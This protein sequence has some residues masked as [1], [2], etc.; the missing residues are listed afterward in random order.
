MRSFGMASN[1]LQ[2]LLYVDSPALS[3]ETSML[4]NGVPFVVTLTLRNEQCC[5][6][7]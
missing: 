6:H 3:T 2:L 1:C 5:K 4:P 7:Y